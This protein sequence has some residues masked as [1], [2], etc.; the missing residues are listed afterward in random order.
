VFENEG[1]KDQV[2][3][4]PLK[5]Y[6]P[7]L[8]VRPRAL[9]RQPGCAVSTADADSFA[10]AR[11]ATNACVLRDQ[12]EARDRILGGNIGLNT[13]NNEISCASAAQRWRGAA[14]RVCADAP[15]CVCA[16]RHQ[17]V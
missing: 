14:S 9:A 15:A 5:F 4:N 17:G 1:D 3:R 7:N 12:V 11:F 6:K 10:D 16:R 2:H 8:H 13:K